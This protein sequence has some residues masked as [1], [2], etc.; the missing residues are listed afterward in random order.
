LA[1]V[2]PP[3]E[4]QPLT[5]TQP[6]AASTAPAAQPVDQLSRDWLLA[7]E[8]RLVLPLILYYGRPVRRDH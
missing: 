7:A 6:R 4:L 5:R 3:G 2:A 8:V 1:Q